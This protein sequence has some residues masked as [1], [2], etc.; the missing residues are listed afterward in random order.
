MKK[1]GALYAIIALS[2]L[3]LLALW[4]IDNVQGSLKLEK[5]NHKHTQESLATAIAAG[6]Q[7]EAAYN[8]AL[9]SAA[10]QGQA[11]QAC[12][13]REAQAHEAQEERDAILQA[14][15]PRPRTTTEQKQVVD[16]ETRANIA[17]RLNRP[18]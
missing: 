2:L 11:T 4:R 1:K 18:L 17:N 9:S 6:K 15:Q 16:D 7:W 12:L 13:E 3:L 5:A 10:A 8:E 14:A